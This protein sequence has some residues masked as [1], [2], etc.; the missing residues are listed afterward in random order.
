MTYPTTATAVSRLLDGHRMGQER[1]RVLSASGQLGFGIVQESFERGL[2]RKPHFIGCDMGSIDPGPFYLGSG[3]M[4]APRDMVRRDLEMVLKAARQLDVPLIIGSAGTA[5]AKPHLEETLSLLKEVAD[6]NGLSFSV[7]IVLSD[8]PRNLL[9][10]AIQHGRLKSLDESGASLNLPL[11]NEE[12][13]MSAGHIVAQCGT[14]TLMKALAQKP[15]VLIAGRSCD[16]AIFAALPQMLGYDAALSLHMAKIIE[17]TSLCCTPGG[18]DA[19]LAEL[20]EFDFILESMNPA[21]HA[22]PASV[23]AHALYEQANP[24]IVEEPEGTLHLKQ[25]TY[26]ALDSHRTQVSGAQFVPRLSPTLKVEGASHAGARAVL[27]AGVADPTMISIMPSALQEVSERVRKLVPGE[28]TMV[29]HLYGQGAVRELAQAK[30][31]L[32]EIG[33]VVE[34]LAPHAAMAKTAAAVFKQNLL[35]FGFPG[36]LTTGGNLAFAFTPSEID[37]YECYQFV[38]YHLLEGVSPEDVFRIELHQWNFDEVPA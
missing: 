38:L 24:W 17:C 14:H 16:T 34:F 26:L 7:A 9:I 20:G 15:D 4:A 35:H 29:P 5:G 22:T 33:L 19:I 13:V 8:V 21:A 18:R 28:W 27:L 2:E 37:A 3:Q 25:A 1:L 31:S 12:K 10:K 23:A 11:P 30:R 6:A 32:H 36:R